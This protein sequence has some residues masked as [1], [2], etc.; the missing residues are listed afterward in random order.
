MGQNNA[1]ESK[2]AAPGEKHKAPVRQSRGRM[3][4]YGKN[5]VVERIKAD[6]GTIRK[7]YLRKRTE[8]SEVVKEAK[9]AGLSFE[10]VEEKEISDLCPGANTQGVAAEV[11]SFEYAPFP[12]ILEKCLNGSSVMVFADEIT[13]P[14]NLGGIIRNLACLGGFSLVIPEHNSADVN[15]TVLKVANGGENFLEISRVTNIAEA[16]RRSRE[17]GVWVV[18]ADANTAGNIAEAEWRYPLAV[19]IG[20]EGRGIRHGIMKQLDEKVALPMDGARL[21]Y[22][23][24]VA[25]ALFCYE[26]R[27]KGKCR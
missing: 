23:A 1:R 6:P 9:K 16:V 2:N 24:A 21:S 18:G 14:Q 26:I 5:P 13:D 7:L 10:S 17:K 8:L 22:N 15:E 27:R 20:S 25:A 11:D 3:M 4:L 19:V 12:K